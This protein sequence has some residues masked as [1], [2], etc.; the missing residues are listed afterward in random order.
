MNRENIPSKDANL[1]IIRRNTQEGLWSVRAMPRLSGSLSLIIDGPDYYS[2]RW[3]T[4]VPIA[5]ARAEVL[6]FALPAQEASFQVGSRQSGSMKAIG[7]DALA[8]LPEDDITALRVDGHPDRALYWPTPSPADVRNG[9]SPDMFIIDAGPG[10]TPLP[11]AGLIKRTVDAFPKSHVAGTLE[12]FQEVISLY[13]PQ[14][15]DIE[16][17]DQ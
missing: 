12:S 6:G 1:R 14:L 8:E 10:V 15:V 4:R 17:E 3:K 11:F 16:K 7:R 2:L 13:L 9:S 5:R